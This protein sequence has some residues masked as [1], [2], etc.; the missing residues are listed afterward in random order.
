MRKAA[1]SLV[2]VTTLA[3]L[4]GAQSGVRAKSAP[5]VEA[6]QPRPDGRDDANANLLIPKRTRIV[7]EYARVALA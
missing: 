6:A 2:M 3:M 1:M 4:A 7:I 5:A